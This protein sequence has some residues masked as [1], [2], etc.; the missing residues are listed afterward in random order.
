LWRV[1]TLTNLAKLVSL[2]GDLQACAEYLEGA[3][4]NLQELGLDD[5]HRHAQVTL[6][7]LAGTYEAMGDYLKAGALR[8]RLAAV[9]EDVHHSFQGL[10]S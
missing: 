8:T 5:A 4:Q 9:Q 10:T 7:N 2:G 3:L 6:E 1:T